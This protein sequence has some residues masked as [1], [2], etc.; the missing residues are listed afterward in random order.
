MQGNSIFSGLATLG[1]AEKSAKFNANPSGPL[2]A[3]RLQNKMANGCGTASLILNCTICKD[4]KIT[5][6]TK[7]RNLNFIKLHTTARNLALPNK[8]LDGEV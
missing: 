7:H 8:F 4:A 1:L 2:P 5:K 6:K 3:S